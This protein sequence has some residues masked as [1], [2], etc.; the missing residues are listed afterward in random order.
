LTAA[1]STAPLLPRRR[2]PPRPPR[3]RPKPQPQ[4]RRRRRRSIQACGRPGRAAAG[5]SRRS[6]G[7]EAATINSRNYNRSSPAAAP[8]AAPA[9][10]PPPPRGT[11]RRSPR[12]APPAAA[13]PPPARPAAGVKMP[14]A[15]EVKWVFM[16]VVIGALYMSKTKTNNGRISQ[17]SRNATLVARQP[18]GIQAYAPIEGLTASNQK[19]AQ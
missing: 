13:A 8:Q 2:R 7:P 1:C 9:A 4:R 6:L 10:P 16:V 17:P 15:P 18:R 12:R 19:S 11:L 3:R 5:R 14:E